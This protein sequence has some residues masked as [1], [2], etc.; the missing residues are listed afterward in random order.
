MSVRQRFKA[1]A[2]GR[3]R[4]LDIDIYTLI[5]AGWTGRDAQAVEHHI[6]E[7]EAIGVRRPASVPMFYRV[8]TGN[9][10]GAP[11][12]Q[13]AGRHS[14]GEVEFVLVADVDGLWVGLGSDHT[15]RDLEK[16]SVSLS[17]QVCGKPIAASLWRFDE[18]ADHWDE[19]ELCSHALIR[20]ERRLYQ[21]GTV[22]AL[23]RPA[24]LIDAYCATTH[25]RE[26]RLPPGA[27][28]F[29]GTLP[30]HGNLEFADRFEIELRDP[31]LDRSLLHAY[32]VE[33]LPLAD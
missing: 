4:D 33:A 7:L 5:I 16:H 2:N 30:V 17:K 22:T 31:H 21:R 24:D 9:L 1:H 20:G 25:T 28:M 29:C 26:H 23:R 19:L 27:I 10:T 11:S 8:S 18:V 6:R 14:T 13:V 15:D 12:L 3:A 32:D